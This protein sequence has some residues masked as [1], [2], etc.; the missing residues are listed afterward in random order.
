MRVVG[1][2]ISKILR[3]FRRYWSDALFVLL[4]TGLFI[5]VTWEA[6]TTRLVTTSPGADYWEHSATMRALLD[7]PWHPKNPHLVSPAS[8]PRFVPLFILAAL[9]GRAFGVDALGAMGIVT[10]FNMALLLAGIFVFFR[11]YFRDPRASLYGLIVMFCSWFDAFHFSNV[12]QIKILFS[13]AG[14]PS[15]SALGMCLLGFAFTQRTLR[16]RSGWA[17]LAGVSVIWAIVMITHPLTAMLGFTGAGLLGLS[18]PGVPWRCRAQVIAAIGLGLALS[19]LWPYFSMK[20][21]LV[22]GSQETVDS[23]MQ[24]IVGTGEEPSGANH[25]FYRLKGLLNTLGLALVGVPVALALLFR[26]RHWFIALGALAML[27]PFVINMHVQLPLGHRFVLLAIFYLQVAVVWLLLALTPGAPNSPGWL[28]RGYRGIVPSLL[29][30]AVLGYC[31]WINWNSARGRFD[32]ASAR[33][34]GEDSQFAHIARRAAE[35]SGP[36]AVILADARNSWPLPTFGPKVLVL[37]HGNPLVLDE[38]EREQA[39]GRF[40]HARTSDAERLATLAHYGVTHVL[41]NARQE[42]P[43]AQFLSSRAKRELLPAGRVLYTLN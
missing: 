1:P 4:A 14:Y 6:S 27:L 7:N 36:H 5:W 2:V 42:R 19:F 23:V 9:I 12:Y 39:V 3:L 24:S 34:R 21:T 26:P 38:G 29:V 13:T 40:L 41:L 33:L 17:S 43:L 8:S 28:T 32:T 15:T 31:A 20:G 11:T 10:G 22:G 37:L 30:A 16:R 18:E 25:P 35:L